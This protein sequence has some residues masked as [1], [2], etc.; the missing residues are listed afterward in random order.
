M[1]ELDSEIMRGILEKRGYTRVDDELTADLIIFNTC[2]V[3]D[4]AERKALGKLGLIARSRKDRPI[5]GITGCMASAKRETLLE[6]VPYL[7]FV[8]GT[9]N[10]HTLSQV[11]DE[12][13]ASNS[14]IVRADPKFEVELDYRLAKRDDPVKACV[15]IIRGCNKHCTYCIVPKTRGPECS[16]HPDDIVVEC[17]QL[18]AEGYKE[19]LLLGQNVNSYGKDNSHW[20]TLFPDLLYRIDKIPGIGRVRFMTSHP[21]D[22]SE[23]LM[24]AIRDLPSLCEFVHFPL[25]AGSNR[26]LNKMHRMYTKEEYTDK[27]ALL[28]SYVPNVALGTDIIVGFPTETEDEFLETQKALEEIRFSTTFLFCYSRREGTPAARW[29]DDVSE[30]VKDQRL[31][32]LLATQEGVSNKE[33]Q[34]LLNETVEVL[35]EGP[36]TKDASMLKGRTRTWKQVVFPGNLSLVGTYQQIRIHSFTHQTCVGE[37]VA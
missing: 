12:V 28:R 11:L 24:K 16:R 3:R 10:I 15:S 13:L 6:K 18:V 22:I 2:S 9:N 14:R 32:A 21:V 25:Q 27:V 34:L 17:Q 31:Q 29:P 30:S 19:I 23:D 5:I 36:S 8:V 35:V 20:N 1:N 26:V 33:L 4:L 7:D 37:I